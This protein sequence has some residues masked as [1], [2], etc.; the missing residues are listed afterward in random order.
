MATKPITVAEEIE[1]AI[2][3]GSKERLTEIARQV[4]TTRPAMNA[5]MVDVANAGYSMF[6]G[7]QGLAR[8]IYIDYLAAPPGSS[9]RI[10]LYNLLFKCL[11]MA[12]NSGARSVEIM[13]DDEIEDE[14][15]SILLGKAVRDQG[16]PRTAAGRE[17]VTGF[18]QQADADLPDEERQRLDA[19]IAKLEE[20]NK[21]D[22]IAVRL[23]D[24]DGDNAPSD[25]VE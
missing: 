23:K 19:E 15:N 13:P 11:E 1:Q 24:A 9:N 8:R 10:Q 17:L 18:L 7:A 21:L 3:A 5:S 25:D 4:A 6:H 14:L 2:A 12:A 16:D 22:E 20:I